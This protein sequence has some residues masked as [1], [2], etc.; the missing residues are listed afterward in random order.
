MLPLDLGI[1]NLNVNCTGP[2][3]LGHSKYTFTNSWY[4][5][6]YINSD[7]TPQSVFNYLRSNLYYN[8]IK[9]IV[10]IEFLVDGRYFMYKFILNTYQMK[11]I[12][13]H[14]AVCTHLLYNNYYKFITREC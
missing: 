14:T 9:I 12:L 4:M 1:Q 13:K 11:F 7:C 6:N 3:P 2:S 5:Y 8:N 10:I